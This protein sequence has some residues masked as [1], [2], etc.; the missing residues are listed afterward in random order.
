MAGIYVLLDFHPYLDNPLFVRTLKD[1]AQD[2][3]KCARTIVLHQLRSEAAG[4]ARSPGGALR[5]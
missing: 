2:Y 1:I 4:R 3:N 5:G